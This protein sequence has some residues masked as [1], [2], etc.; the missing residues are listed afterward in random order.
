MKLLDIT[1]DITLSFEVGV[2][3]QRPP[4]WVTPRYFRLREV[5]GV[6]WKCWNRA[7]DILYSGSLIF[8]TFLIWFPKSQK[9][10]MGFTSLSFHNTFRAMGFSISSLSFRPDFY[11]TRQVL[12]EIFLK[13]CRVYVEISI[14]KVWNWITTM[15]NSTC[16]MNNSI[17]S[18][19]T[20]T[21]LE[22]RITWQ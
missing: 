5:F 10:G 13:C 2:K 6:R 8:L 12:V 22:N 4:W 7:V 15:K 18:V 11:E 19:I 21:C 3:K 1:K 14:A 9:P 16:C 20:W 17:H